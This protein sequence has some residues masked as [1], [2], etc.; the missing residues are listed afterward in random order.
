[1]WRI[2]QAQEPEDFIVATGK[3]CTVREFATLAFKVAGLEIH[4]RG[5]GLQEVGVLKSSGVVVV[6]VDPAFFRPMEPNQIIGNSRKARE[7]LAW[8]PSSTVSSLITEMVAAC[9][10]ELS[11]EP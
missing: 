9:E 4:F 3:S 2:L 5:K 11:S 6:E 10:A 8:K 1:M 7:L